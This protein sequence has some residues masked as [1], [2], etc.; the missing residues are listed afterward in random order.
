MLPEKFQH[1]LRVLNTNIDGQLK[2]IHAMTAIKG[3]GRRY[4]TVVC[5]KADI[6]VT[7]RAGELSEDDIDKLV[8]VMSNPRQYKIPDWFLNRQRDVDDGKC[9]QIMSNALETKLREDL[10]KLKRI[11]AHRGIRH[12]WGL[13]DCLFNRLKQFF[14]IFCID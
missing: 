12:Y 11:R 6:D 4:A 5:K 2:I 9:S 1:I 10:E 14:C 8:T 3:V 13:V 7:K